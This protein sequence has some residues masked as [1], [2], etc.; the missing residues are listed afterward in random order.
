MAAIRGFLNTD[1]PA[2]AKIWNQ[3]HASIDSNS[4]T[5]PAIWDICVLSK[6]YFRADELAIALDS[7]N[8]PLG[9]V[10]F[11]FVGDKGLQSLSQD[12][13]AIHALCITPNPDEDLI[14][15]DLLAYAESSLIERN[16]RSCSGI[17]GGERT[18]FYLGI[19]DGDNLMG[20]LASDQKSQRWLSAAGF[21]PLRPTE[22]WELELAMFRP[23]MDRMQIQA[24]RACTIGRILDEDY[25]HWWTS[26]AL[27]HCDQT[28]FHLMTKSSSRLVGVL[29]GW[30]PEPSILGLDASIVRITL[31]EPPA[32]EE[33]REQFLYLASESLRQL[34]QERKHLARAVVS[35]DKQRMVSLLLRLGFRSV[36]HGLVFEKAFHGTESAW[37]A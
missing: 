34:Q 5:S 2:L 18:G 13:A 8:N 33:A 17:G 9:F 28:R 12:H 1:T 32:S 22:C 35:A 25:E 6:P 36:D 21:R 4:R 23:P 16:A 30:F 10:H 24:R 29:T 27:G 11:G 20:V 7:N 31:D 3:H 14:A 37:P 26:T 19:A 15:K